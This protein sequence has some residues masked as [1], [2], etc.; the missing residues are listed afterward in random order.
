ME[1]VNNLQSTGAEPEEQKQRGEE[2]RQ[3]FFQEGNLRNTGE[4]EQGQGQD[5][6]GTLAEV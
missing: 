6:P 5:P 4:A 2:W 1:K 3:Q